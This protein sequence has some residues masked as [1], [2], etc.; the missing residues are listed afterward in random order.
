MTAAATAPL[1]RSG[2]ASATARQFRGAVI[3][4]L[5]AVGVGC[6][7]Y[8]VE[9][10][11]FAS[12]HRVVQ[13]PTAAMMRACGLAHF[14]VGWLFLFT[15]HRLRAG[16]SLA[17]LLMVSLLGGSLCMVVAW[18][19]MTHSPL[20]FALFYGYFLI[21]EILDEASLFRASGDAPIGPEDGWLLHLL[22][23]AVALLLT[24][25]L[26][27]GYLIYGMIR[28]LGV[29]N[30]LTAAVLA[31]MTAL[32][33]AGGSV[34]AA[35]FLAVGRQVHGNVPALVAAYRPL[36][37]VYGSLLAILLLGAVAGS[38][39]FN[40]IILIH[41]GSWLLFVYSQLGRNPAPRCQTFWTWLRGTPKGFLV[42]HLSAI[43]L[44]LA[45]QV[46]R[47]YVWQR[48]GFVCQLFAA[49]TFPFWSLMH[50]TTSFWRPR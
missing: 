8:L 16:R 4:A 33:L 1:W 49:S 9:T 28:G 26:G 7:I 40:L 36:L 19:D 3:F 2:Q 31:G 45:V 10:H 44:V 14:W 29:G 22:S 38:V 32:C 37:G 30:P 34:L 13:N 46:L 23:W 27:G 24:A 20:T 12:R 50:I 48:S 47:N 35:R 42:L 6:L 11:V 43:F 5:F 41:A 17:R 21:H 15:S 18:A 25:V 39:V